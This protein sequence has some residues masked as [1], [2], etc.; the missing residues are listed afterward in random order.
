MID[1]QVLTELIS[2]I[3]GCF[4]LTAGLLSNELRVT[5]ATEEGGLNK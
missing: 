3:G 2:K 4:S 5:D 1:M